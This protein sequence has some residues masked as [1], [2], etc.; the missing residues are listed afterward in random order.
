M[1]ELNGTTITGTAAG[2][3]QKD[4]FVSFGYDFANATIGSS[5]FT[6]SYFQKSFVRVDKNTIIVLE[7]T[8]VY[9]STSNHNWNIVL[10]KFS[11]DGE[12]LDSYTYRV[13]NNA[14]S[15]AT[16]IDINM[17]NQK[18]GILVY[19]THWLNETVKY[20]IFTING[21]S[22]TFGEEYDLYNN[23]EA[24]NIY[25]VENFARNKVFSKK[26]L[27]LNSD[28]SLTSLIEH[29]VEY[30]IPLESSVNSSGN[31]I[32]LHKKYSRVGVLGGVSGASSFNILATSNRSSSDQAIY[33]YK[34]SKVI[35]KFDTYY[36]IYDTN[37]EFTSCSQI[38]EFYESNTISSEN[39]TSHRFG[40]TLLH[41]KNYA[42]N[43]V[44]P[45]M[46]YAY[47]FNG[48]TL[49]STGELKLSFGSSGKTYTSTYMIPLSYNKFA[50][51]LASGTAMT[52]YSVV[53]RILTVPIKVYPALIG[54]EF[55][56]VALASASNGASVQVSAK[57]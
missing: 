52:D 5:G 17:F 20:K 38:T 24:T 13:V 39:Y 26:V 8:D 31:S 51:V 23:G 29:S 19:K 6:S 44:Y 54:E 36:L 28:D 10:Y 18:K 11:D 1:A 35:A 46:I 37:S 3:I 49:T 27:K 33:Y 16:C 32:A 4:Q 40:R 42:E 14:Y 57:F 34:N 9:G 55:D 47:D 21:T 43:S 25:N 53:S 7:A 48:S 12:Y 22:I 45:A 56:G 41:F 30:F 50:V 15:I 2:T